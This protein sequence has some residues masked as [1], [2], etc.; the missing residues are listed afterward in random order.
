MATTIPFDFVLGKRLFLLEHTPSAEF[1][2]ILSRACAFEVRMERQTYFS[3]SYG[4]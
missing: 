3:I 2:M 4:L 1:R